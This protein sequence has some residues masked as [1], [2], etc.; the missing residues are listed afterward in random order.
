MISRVK[1]KLVEVQEAAVVVERDGIGLSVAVPGFAVGELAAGRG[2]EVT[3]HTML[4]IEGNQA[5]GHMEPVL[6]GF[7]QATDKVFFRRFIS[8]KGIGWKKALRALS[9]PVGRIAAWIESADIAS[10]KRLPGIGAR[11]A[12]LIVAELK[13]KLEDIALAAGGIE[14]AD[15]G[16]FTEDQNAALE[17]IVS[18]DDPRIEAERWLER[19]AM[20]HAEIDSPDD[21][22][23]AAY[24]VKTGAEG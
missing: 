7:P 18:L 3:L 4:F 21:W 9:E 11:A 14:R 8:V 19:A 22:I 5:G 20:L 23:R 6:V 1:G 15:T 12:E 24:R 13:G 10:L 2:R 17:V 16:R